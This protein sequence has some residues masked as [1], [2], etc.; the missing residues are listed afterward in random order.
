MSGWPGGAR[1]ACA[2]TFDLDA[3]TLWMARGVSEPV[4]LSQGRFGPVEALPRILD[5]LRGAEIHSTFFIPAWV[6]EHYPDAVRAI[7]AGGHEVG[8]HGDVHERVSEL[9]AEKEEAI[10]TRSIEVITKQAG[11][12]PAGYRAPSWQLSER[13]LGLLMRHGFEYSSNMMDRLA[14][15]LHE[16]VDGASL[17]EIPVSWV[18]D[19][20]PYFLFTGQ[21]AIQAPGPV[22]QGWLAEFDGICEAGGVANFTFHPQIIG[23]PSRFAC[24]RE[25]VEHA[26]KTPGVWI[27]R[28]D[29]I[30][31]HWRR[32][33]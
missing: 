33:A 17:V 9:D 29:E 26:K 22:L 24:L 5:L 1:A 19:D 27:A 28:L 15:Y 18:L 10:L 32:V 23:R 13:T 12:T 21:R 11:K 14:P 8:C 2:F 30:A 25:L 6:V 31:A 3:E 20:A 7:V 4:A 16:A